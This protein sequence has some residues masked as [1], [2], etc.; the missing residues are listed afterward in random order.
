[1]KRR[2]SEPY[3]DAEFDAEV[4]RTQRS[5]WTYV[6]VRVVMLAVVFWFLARGIAVHGVTAGFLLLPLAVEFVMVMWVGLFL[7][8]FVVDCPAFAKTGRR[9]ILVPFWTL[10]IAGIISAVLGWEDGT[11]DAERINPGWAAGWQEI[12]T[13]GLVWAVVAE[14]LGLMLST[15]PEVVRWRRVGGKFVWNSIFSLGVRGAAALLIGFLAIFVLIVLV[16]L[17]AQ[18]VDWVLRAPHRAAWTVYGFLLLVEVG[19]LA[20]GVGMHRDLEVEEASSTA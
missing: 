8:F 9:P 12:W 14:V 10:A 13:T 18:P 20:I 1:M 3:T 7:S 4:L 17:E 6:A 5:D 2:S 19:G 16:A 11:F 15:A